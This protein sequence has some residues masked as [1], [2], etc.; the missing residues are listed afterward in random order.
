MYDFVGNFL[1]IFSFGLAIVASI[2]T[3]YFMITLIN[4]M[5]AWADT[6][7]S[8]ELKDF[9][10]EQNKTKSMIENFGE[11]LEREKSERIDPP[12]KKLR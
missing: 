10:E 6:R 3:L 8:Q 11:E 5:F 12:Y 1:Y 2:V 9:V 4:Y 7:E